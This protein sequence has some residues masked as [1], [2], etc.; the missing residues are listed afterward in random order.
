M[1]SLFGD[2][3]APSKISKKPTTEKKPRIQNYPL[4]DLAG[5][6]E[7]NDDIRDI[8]IEEPRDYPLGTKPWEALKRYKELMDDINAN[9][10]VI[11]KYGDPIVIK[12]KVG[13]SD[14]FS[15]NVESELI[16]ISDDIFSCRKCPLANQR[17]RRSCKA[18]PG[19]GNWKKRIMIVGEGPG[20]TE[21]NHTNPGDDTRFGS[22]F[23]GKSGE[24]LVKILKYLGLERKDVYITNAIKCRAT[25]EG[26]GKLEDRPP[27]AHELDSCSPYL[28]KQIQ[29]IRPWLII[30]MGR[31]AASS[32]LKLPWDLKDH[33]EYRDDIFSYPDNPQIKV[34]TTYH[35]A[36]LLRN[37][38]EWLPS[39]ERLKPLKAIIT[40]LK[41]DLKNVKP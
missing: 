23:I 3:E 17:L 36:Y 2:L 40:K 29:L 34:W 33:K 35:P 9:K 30:T 16:E 31:Q 6:R 4:V 20:G 38:D 18:V 12:D 24:L 13:Y 5:R 41:E 32:V 27:S 8:K 10:Q 19:V 1:S 14:V 21:E 28:H 7:D 26:N 25:Q 15:S 11:E 39:G 37:E 22:P